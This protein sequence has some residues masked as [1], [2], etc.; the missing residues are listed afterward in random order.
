VTNFHLYL[1]RREDKAHIE[2][3]PSIQQSQLFI[4]LDI[5]LTRYCL[6][7]CNDSLCQQV[8][9]S[10]FSPLTVPSSVLA[11]FW[12]DPPILKTRRPNSGFQKY[13]SRQ[14]MAT[15][16]CIWSFIRWSRLDLLLGHDSNGSLLSMH[17]LAHRNFWIYIRVRGEFSFSGWF[18]SSEM[19]GFDF[20]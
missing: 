15:R 7:I 5:H 19:V 4:P 3:Y 14:R 20:Y 9:L 11:D 2:A 16:S 18:S 17:S 8:L 10:L 12:R 1:P 13:L 6:L